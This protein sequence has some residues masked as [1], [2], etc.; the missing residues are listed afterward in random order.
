MKEYVVT[1]D[2]NGLVKQ[3]K[4]LANSKKEAEIKAKAKYQN[5]KVID[6]KEY[7]KS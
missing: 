5:C 7:I 6:C 2:C 1:L 3:D 4:V